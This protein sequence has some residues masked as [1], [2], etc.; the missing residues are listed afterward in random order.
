[1]R[2]GDAKIERC[3]RNA[4]ASWNGWLI[5]RQSPHCAGITSGH[6]HLNLPP[7]ESGRIN[8]QKSYLLDGI[9]LE[10]AEWRRLALEIGMAFSGDGH[11]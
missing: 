7:G 3:G 11:L 10:G 9:K 5:I 4:I 1:M 8:K 2:S 6:Q